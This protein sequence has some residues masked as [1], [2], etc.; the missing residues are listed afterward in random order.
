MIKPGP[1]WGRSPV[2]PV[3]DGFWGRL[4]SSGA[5]L[6]FQSTDPR[7]ISLLGVAF[8]ES[9]TPSMQGQTAFQWYLTA[10]KPVADTLASYV[11]NNLSAGL[12]G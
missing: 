4:Q 5:K 10:G 9:A 1:L 12:R 2:D 6:V 11:L 3:Y 7:Y 8:G